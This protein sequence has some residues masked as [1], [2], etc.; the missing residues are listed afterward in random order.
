MSIPSKVESRLQA[1]LKRFQA[2]LQSA[3]IRDVNE[4]DTVIIVTD[5]LSEVFGFD[6]YTDITSEF[7][8][9]GTFCDL[10]IKAEGKPQVLIEVKA[11]GLELKEQFAKQA[12]DYAANQGTE[13]VLLTN[14]LIWQVYKVGFTQPISQELVLELNLGLLSPKSEDHLHQLYCLTKEGRGK[15]L[16]EDYHE[17]KQA[18]SRFSIGQMILTDSV[19]DVI[20]R[21][22][23]KISPGVRIENESIKNVLLHEVLKREVLEGDKPEEARRKILRL[24]NRTVKPKSFTAES[25]LSS[26]H[27]EGLNSVK[28]EQQIGT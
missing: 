6:K 4:S 21:E 11:I 28:A 12:I 10:A 15:C 1:G 8:I 26:T 19:L 23:R 24:Q 27:N 2:I 18:M 5:I 7:S 16:L 14:G 22:L 9:R 17:K 13:W 25:S 3:K 20:R